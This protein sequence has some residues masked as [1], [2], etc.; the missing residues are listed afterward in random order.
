MFVVF[1]EHG[2]GSFKIWRRY[3]VICVQT[4]YIN[5]W[6]GSGL[7]GVFKNH[8]VGRCYS[9]ITIF[10]VVKQEIHVVATGWEQRIVL[11]ILMMMGGWCFSRVW[12]WLSSFKPAAANVVLVLWCVQGFRLAAMPRFLDVVV[13]TRDP[14]SLSSANAE[15]ESKKQCC[16]KG[17]LF[18]LNWRTQTCIEVCEV[19][20]N[21]GHGY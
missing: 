16:W 7:G 12:K 19:L 9:A 2:E 3:I 21:E 6:K 8:G 1:V 11:W 18:L 4:C 17:A 15:G 13:A 10:A 14:I 5:K 20:Y